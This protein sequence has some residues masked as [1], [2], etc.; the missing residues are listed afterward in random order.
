MRE[1][2][3]G[4]ANV[5]DTVELEAYYRALGQKDAYA[6]WTVA[7]AIE[8]WEPKPVSVPKIWKYK[9]LRA[10]VLR[11][12]D[13]VSAEKAAR[14]V[15][16]LEN[17]GRKG[18]SACVGWL[19]TGLQV[20]RPGEFTSAHKH[21][22]AALRFILEGSGA[23]TVV[24]GHQLIL[25]A[26]DFVLTPGGTWHD[27]GVIDDGQICIWQDGLDMLLVNVLD[28]NYYAVHHDIRQTASYPIDDSPALYGGPGLLPADEGWSKA[29][30][31]LL[32]YRWDQSYET[33]Q[34]AG[35]VSDGSPFDGIIMDYVNPVT[36][37][38]VMQTIGASIQLLRPGEA[39]RAHRHTGNI[40]Y[41]GALGSGVAIINGRKFLWEEG[42]I[43]VV[44]SWAWH[45]FANASNR[46]DAVL[47]SFHDLPA[48]KALGLYR[49]EPY[50]DHGG[51][52]KPAGD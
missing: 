40:V 22:A 19:Y 31:P 34:R 47:F 3:V 6:L 42:D 51:H 28:A 32:K 24:D 46:D 23:Y 26:R 25:G 14:R 39:T 12:L 16:A 4:R 35:R 15:V 30:S 11:A 50:G 29:H 17:P 52:Q 8:P 33:L 21:A 43:F 38:A 44:P 20:M 1:D 48:M 2:V 41:T 7:N 37:G 27:H 45:E 18:S 9:D 10:D 5:E 36:G 49:M 13:L